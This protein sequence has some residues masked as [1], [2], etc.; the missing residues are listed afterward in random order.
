M[1]R[2][3]LVVEALRNVLPHE[4]DFIGDSAVRE[5]ATGP[6]EIVRVEHGSNLDLSGILVVVA[7]GATAIRHGIDIYVRLSN[8][9]GRRASPEELKDAAKAA[10]SDPVTDA[11]PPEIREKVYQYLAEHLSAELIAELSRAADIILFVSADPIDLD[12]LRLQNEEREIRQA[13]ELSAGRE[14]WVV[15]ASGSAR[16][17]DLT[18]A[19]LQVNPRVVHFSG[20]GTDRGGVF[21]EDLSGRSHS[22]PQDALAELFAGFG[23]T[24][25]CVVLNACFSESQ[26][27]AIAAHI[28]F[29]VGTT[30]AVPDAAAIEFS[31]G[32]YTALGEGRTFPEAY[33]AGRIHFHS[34]LGPECP[35]P[36]LIECARHEE[37]GGDVSRISR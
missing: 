30:E 5:I 10:P 31:V 8:T 21:L 20:H 28:P 29:V 15:E 7:A 22:I 35:P 12:R 3:D 9:L 4:C 16:L 6:V 27:R 13:L 24:V 1:E 23:R 2:S 18:R 37:Q 36:V 33:S 14:R 34:T 32:F 25:Q 11:L 26:A 17:R 19:L